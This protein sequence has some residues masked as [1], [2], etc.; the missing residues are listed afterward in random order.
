MQILDKLK[1]KVTELADSLLGVDIS[2]IE[3]SNLIPDIPTTPYEMMSQGVKG[4]FAELTQDFFAYS[5]ELLARY[6]VWMVDLSR[7]P[8]FNEVLSGLQTGAGILL[9]VLF[10]KRVAQGLWAL[11]TDEE[12]PNWAALVGRTVI[13]A[14]AV[15]AT[16]ILLKDY[17]IP[18]ANG[19]SAW[20]LSFGVDT[21]GLA[22]TNILE[23]FSPG[24]TLA[25][26][27]LAK[28]SM[29]AVYVGGLFILTVV[30]AI[31]FIELGLAC[32]MGVVCS[33]F[34]VDDSEMY[35][36]YWQEAASVTFTQCIH[37]YLMFLS[38][39]WVASGDLWKLILATGALFVAY[40]GPKVL[41]QYIYTSGAGQAIGGASRWAFYKLVSQK[42]VGTF[43][44]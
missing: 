33:V 7:I 20:I 44:K 30:G 41:R 4:I 35:R 43:K 18:I 1:K 6:L 2:R 39:N 8:K 29:I 36:V 9:G 22:K 26:M 12:E 40:R 42:F 23:K 27:G 19:I 32:L 13:A 37:V 10:L 5:L 3:P 14:F 31:R 34:I 16:P 38:L 28:L 25:E 11:V 24:V 17:I 21:S 15:Y